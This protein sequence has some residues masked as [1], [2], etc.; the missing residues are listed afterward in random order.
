M[1]VLEARAKVSVATL[2]WSKP[3]SF[4]EPLDFKYEQRQWWAPRFEN[5]GFLHFE[6]S[7]MISWVKCWR[8]MKNDHHHSS[9]RWAL[10]KALIWL[11]LRVVNIT[12]PYKVYNSDYFL[13]TVFGFKKWA[14]TFNPLLSILYCASVNIHASLIQ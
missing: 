14:L 5:K 2:R 1:D 4:S 13:V 10:E 7:Y 6:R 9:Y 12:L 8:T 11:E 3:L